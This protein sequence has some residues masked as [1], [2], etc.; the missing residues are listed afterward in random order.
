MKKLN[1]LFIVTSIFTICISVKS[2]AGVWENKY[3]GWQY[4]VKND[5][6]YKD[7]EH[8]I[9]LKNGEKYYCNGSLTIDG[10][11]YYFDSKGFMETGWHKLE[12][13]KLVYIEEDGNFRTEPLIE[14]NRKIYY[15]DSDTHF[16]TNP[17]GED[18]STDIDFGLWYIFNRGE[19]SVKYSSIKQ[20]LQSYKYAIESKELREYIESIKTAVENFEN[21]KNDFK[22]KYMRE[23]YIEYG[24]LVEEY[25]NLTVH[26]EEYAVILEAGKPEGLIE[27][28]KLI[29]EDLE[30]LEKIDSFLLGSYLSVQ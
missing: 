13:D 2:Y 30:K 7:S 25:K 29:Y 19:L 6:Q 8:L 9:E 16:C 12:N 4:N 23:F 26:L 10:K 28:K 5:E 15:F 27:K 18:A 20:R 24:A 1:Y 14:S 17:E 22:L 3:G 11:T 21:L